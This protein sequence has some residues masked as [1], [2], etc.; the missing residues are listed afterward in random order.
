MYKSFKTTALDITEEQYRKDGALHY[1]TL[2]TF[3]R[4]GFEGLNT[5]FDKKDSPSLTFGSA[6]DSLITGGEEEFNSKFI[7]ANYK[8]LE[9]SY[10]NIITALYNLYKDSYAQITLIPDKNIIQMTEQLSFYK[11]WKPETRVKAIK[12][13]GQEYYN[14][15]NSSSNKTIL[16]N[17]QYTKIVKTVA[18]LKENVATKYYFI[19]D[20]PFDDSIERLYQLKF[21]AI[22]D[23]L[24]YSCM[25][26]LLIVDHLTKIVYPCDLKTSSHKEYDFY[27]SFIGYNYDIQARLYWRI[28]RATMD[29]DPV[30]K[31]YKLNDYTFIVI[32]GDNL[33]PLTWHYSDT[34][35]QGTLY[36]GKSQ[37][38]ECKDPFELGKE[39]NFYLTTRPA[40]PTGIQ[41]R[42]TNSLTQWLNTL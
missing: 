27:K 5:L 19:S 14:L 32:N 40:V 13:K 31:D 18:T 9:S 41:S 7:V 34:Q 42:E 30:F 3:S 39:L 4:K 33:K 29:K 11:H 26:D 28:I 36:Y 10:I 24:T 38:I 2:A 8:A 20:N 17:E 23:N 22:F 15:L 1:S 12:E 37:Q 21:R 16:N 25:A 6:V 35:T